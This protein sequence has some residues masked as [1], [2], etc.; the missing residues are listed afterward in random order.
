MEQPKRIKKMGFFAKLPEGTKVVH[1][2][3]KWGNPYKV[4]EYGR[5][6]ALELYRGYISQK[7]AS[8]ELDISEL[9][10]KNLACFC[11]LDEPCHADILLELAN[12]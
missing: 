9:K 10:G 1:R 7:L 2:P 8:G 6:K 3:S 5:E 12:Q 11:S 4:D